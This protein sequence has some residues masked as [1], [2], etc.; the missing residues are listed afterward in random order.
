MKSN[1][2]AHPWWMSL[3]W[4]AVCRAAGWSILGVIAWFW[5]F[6]GGG[7]AWRAGSLAAVEALAALAGVAWYVPRVRAESQWRAALDRYAEQEQARR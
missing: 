4:A 7:P 3:A 1:T 6:P 2:A 5:L